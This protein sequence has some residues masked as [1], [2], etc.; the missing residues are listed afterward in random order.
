M[1]NIQHVDGTQ[2]NL[3]SLKNGFFKL[4]IIFEF[5]DIIEG[6]FRYVPPDEC[7]TT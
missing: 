3:V 6:C 4:V 1:N 7:Y 2:A 5:L